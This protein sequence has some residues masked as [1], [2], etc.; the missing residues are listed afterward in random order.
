MGF[1]HLSILALTAI[2]ASCASPKFPESGIPSPFDGKWTGTLPSA[3]PSCDGITFSGEIR[4]GFFLGK[5]SQ[6]GTQYDIWGQ[7]K[8]DGSFDGLIGQHGVDGGYATL[9]FSSNTARGTWGSTNCKGS[10]DIKRAI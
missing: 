4:Y 1:R 3:I 8:Q 9:Q 7:I 2:L 5:A 6:K 10:I